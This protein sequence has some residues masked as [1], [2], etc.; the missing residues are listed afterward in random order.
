MLAWIWRNRMSLATETFGI[1]QLSNEIVA[2]RFPFNQLSINWYLFNAGINRACCP[3]CLF[4]HPVSLTEFE[5]PNV[6]SADSSLLSPLHITS[7][8]VWYLCGVPDFGIPPTPRTLRVQMNWHSRC[9]KMMCIWSTVVAEI[10]VPVDV[11]A[12]YLPRYIISYTLSQPLTT[13]I[14]ISD[15]TTAI[16]NDVYGNST[17]N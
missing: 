7:G 4:L 12:N 16:M 14:Y 6:A 11:P 10:N 1:K 13:D 3:T 5:I 9:W 8:D 2:V 17:T 15:G